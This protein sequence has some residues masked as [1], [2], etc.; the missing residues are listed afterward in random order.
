[1]VTSTSTAHRIGIVKHEYAPTVGNSVNAEV[2]YYS[3]FILYSPSSKIPIQITVG[4]GI[5]AFG[6]ADLNLMWTIFR[7]ERHT[8][9]GVGFQTLSAPAALLHIR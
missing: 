6:I 2:S 8:N 7:P 1:M 5:A 9:G 4:Y 3:C